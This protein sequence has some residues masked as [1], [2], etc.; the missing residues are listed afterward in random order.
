MDISS[1]STY[2]SFILSTRFHLWLCCWIF[3][4][5]RC[6]TF[7]F[8]RRSCCH[9]NFK[10][11]EKN[12]C[13]HF[14]TCKTPE[15]YIT[16]FFMY[17]FFTNKWSTLTPSACGHYPTGTETVCKIEPI[18]HLAASTLNHIICITCLC[19]TNPKTQ[20]MRHLT[21]SRDITLYALCILHSTHCGTNPYCVLLHIYTQHKKKPK[22]QCSM[23][24]SPPPL[25]LSLSLSLSSS[26]VLQQI[27]APYCPSW[28]SLTRQTPW[29][30]STIEQYMYDR[31][32]R[33]STN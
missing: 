4:F 13:I 11:C 7:P 5:N 12:C 15:L 17:A 33:Q 32:S 14:N 23:T 2:Y 6:L 26:A 18:T 19:W 8:N 1:P 9:W 21:G 10:W 16:I 31:T 29:T 27:L 30:A 28:F 20:P 3:T 24:P 25:S 22:I